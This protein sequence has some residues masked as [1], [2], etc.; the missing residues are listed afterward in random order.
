MSKQV[1]LEAEADRSPYQV[2]LK[3]LE[4][5]IADIEAEISNF[6]DAIGKSGKKVISLMEKRIENIQFHVVIKS[7]AVPGE[8]EA[9]LSH[10]SGLLWLQTQCHS[11]CH[12]MPQLDVTA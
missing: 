8:A 1:N 6:L 11:S 7:R 5:G 12:S 9:A 3:G 10:I 4:S 2:E